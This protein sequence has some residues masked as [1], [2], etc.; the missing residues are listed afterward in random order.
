MV[1]GAGMKVGGGEL[2]LGERLPASLTYI[3]RARRPGR[4]GRTGMEMKCG[5]CAQTRLL[6]PSVVESLAFWQL[7]AVKR[8]TEDRPLS[9]SLELNGEKARFNTN[10]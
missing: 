4:A 9:C 8:L 10:A 6:G 5:P 3:R 1:D 2:E 7:A